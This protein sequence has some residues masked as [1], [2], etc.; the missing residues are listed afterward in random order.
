MIVDVPKYSLPDI[1][2]IIYPAL[3]EGGDAL[4]DATLAE[5]TESADRLALLLL[6]DATT[7]SDDK[8]AI[9]EQTSTVGCNHFI[10]SSCIR[11]LLF[12]LA[13]RSTPYNSGSKSYAELSALLYLYALLTFASSRGKGVPER[14]HSF[15][16]GLIPALLSSHISGSNLLLASFCELALTVN[17]YTEPNALLKARASVSTVQISSLLLRNNGMFSRQ[18]TIPQSI[19]F[20][21]ELLSSCWKSVIGVQERRLAQLNQLATAELF[22]Y[23]LSFLPASSP[24]ALK[25]LLDTCIGWFMLDCQ[26]TRDEFLLLYCLSFYSEAAQRS[27]QE[28]TDGASLSYLAHFLVPTVLASLHSSPHDIFIITLRCFTSALSQIT[29]IAFSPPSDATAH[30]CQ[31]SNITPIFVSSLLII[32]NVENATPQLVYGVALFLLYALLDLDEISKPEPLCLEASSLQMY[33]HIRIRTMGNRFLA[34]LYPQIV[35][36]YIWIWHVRIFAKDVYQLIDIDPLTPQDASPNVM[37]TDKLTVREVYTQWFE[38]LPVLNDLI[39]LKHSECPK[40]TERDEVDLLG[41]AQLSLLVLR[42]SIEAVL[43]PNMPLF[44]YYVCRQNV[45]NK[46]NVALLDHLIK[47][48]K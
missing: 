14:R 32:E 36:F 18:T 48:S 45:L 33:G 3:R 23:T 41:G 34:E 47:I 24:Q 21:V 1:I 26:P 28:M 20:C 10:S 25:L 29:T 8:E 9:R 19:S 42:Q 15:I 17:D 38:R 13:A 16:H 43:K 30:V 44:K 37:Y 35:R 31:A 4:S 6:D 7:N 5:L 11:R 39:A 46:R 12:S 22:E 40:D 2:G 27:F